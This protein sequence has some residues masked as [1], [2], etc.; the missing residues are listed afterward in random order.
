MDKILAIVDD[1]NNL[2]QLEFIIKKAFPASHFFSAPDGA[3]GIRMA[4]KEDPEIILVN[5]TRKGVDVCSQLKMDQQLQDRPILLFTSSAEVTVDRKKALEIGV[6]AFPCLPIDEIGLIALIRTFVKIKSTYRNYQEEKELR[7]KTEKELAVNEKRFKQVARKSGVW[8]WEVDA[9]GKYTYFSESGETILGY[10][11]EEV[12]GEKYFY[13]FF[14]PEVKE[15]LKNA[16]MDSFSKKLP[17]VDF[18]NPNIHK[19]GHLVMLETSGVP[20]LDSEGNLTGYR[21]A[22]RDITERKLAKEALLQ[23]EN[24]LN[25]AQD[26]AQMN[27]WEMNLITNRLIGSKNFYQMMGV[28]LGTQIKTEL[29]MERVHPE[30]L[31]IVEEKL[32]EIRA[33]KK[34]VTYDIR[35][36][37]SD[38]KYKWIQNNIVPEFEGENL[39]C[40]KG[41]NIDITEKKE[42]DEKIRY[43][44]ERLSAIIKA[45]PDLIFVIDKNGKYLEVF[46]SKP[47][48]LLITPDNII[49]NNISE[50]FTEEMTSL[51]MGMIREVLDRKEMVVIN[52]VISLPDSPSTN[53]EAR[54]AP[55]DDDKVL[56]LSRDTTLQARKEAEIKKL[57]MAVEQSPVSIVITD[58]N[59]NI[60]YVN[61][62]FEETTGYSFEEALGR[63]P[64]ILQSGMTDK[65][66]YLKMW[67]TIVAGNEWHGE[68]INKKKNGELFWEN[69]SISP[70]HDNTGNITNYLAVKLDIT[71]RKQT[72]E[73]LKQN[74]EKYRYMFV[75]NPQPMWI[76]D[77]ETL[78][79]LE[80][81]RAAINH[82]G[83]SRGE[84]LSMTIKDIRPKEEVDLMMKSVALSNNYYNSFGEWRHCKKNGEIIDVEIISH[85]ITYN[86][87]KARHILVNDIT[88]RKKT[89]NEIRELNANLEEKIEQRTIQLAQANEILMKEIEERKK[90][91]NE[92]M[93]ARIEAER[94]N[95]AKSEFLS[96]M[97]HELRTPMNS[98]LGFAQLLEMG[99]I[100]AKQKK[101]ISHILRSGKHLLDLINEVLDISRIESG[102]LSLSLEPVKLEGVIYETMDIVRLQADNRN[103]N[104]QLVN[105]PSNQLSIKSDRQRLKQILLN[106]ISNAVK[107][108]REG[109]SVTVRT[110]KMP[111]NVEGTVSIRIS[112][113]DTGPG[114]SPEDLPK[115]FQPFE[116]IG[117]EKSSTEGTGLGL[118]VVKKLIDAMGG[119]LGADSEPGNGSTFWF[120]MPYCENQLETAEKSGKLTELESGPTGKNGTILYI[121]DNTSNVELVEQV[122]TIRHSSIQLITNA[123]G[124]QAVKLAITHKPDLILLD[125]NLPDIHGTEVLS[126]LQAEEKT[127]A[128]PV[129]VI[130]ADAIPK[131][132]EKLLKAG[133]KNY[134]TKPIDVLEL[135]KIIDEFVVG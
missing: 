71:E 54:I 31:H 72:E 77:T 15:E 29:F 78:S 45:M 95:L 108:N 83:Y 28:P 105:S 98:I 116:R 68:W 109:G 117:A 56:I 70:I 49:G 133:A 119:N 46:A 24:D 18:E 67:E 82:Y 47:E 101:G 41:V 23:S 17:F 103:L 107:Y 9:L 2:K 21:G 1:P 134:L 110:E 7:I 130:S 124:K 123:R 113:S 125:L 27:S 60:E 97:S 37:M 86:G 55:V 100:N 42:A 99:E 122:L 61:P 25:Y 63:N 88:K 36:R 65:A 8:I 59:A 66:V 14:A 114:I 84:F 80:I 4:K 20:L 51:F 135:M 132:I 120:E 30:D 3:I 12:I 22:D 69:I 11:P 93:K 43:Q 115:L 127:R 35:L 44:N 81:N 52:Y 58:L 34:P 131:S 79:F 92:I 62:A 89:E 126:L 48:K 38:N 19:D 76:Y 94:A 39:T 90:A 118:A 106:L 102:R 104:L 128:I 33:T 111:P 5:L 74:E 53:F 16:A 10:K 32:D 6:E 121:E 85:A 57:S 73:I 87:R 96:R 50:A 26:I 64:R 129:V 40:L 75:N 112:V 13:D 91:E